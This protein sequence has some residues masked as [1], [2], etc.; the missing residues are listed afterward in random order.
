[1]CSVPFSRQSTA[2]VEISRILER[3][4]KESRAV[5]TESLCIIA[6]QKVTIEFS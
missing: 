6:G 3:S 2:A 5:D 1:M 4:Q